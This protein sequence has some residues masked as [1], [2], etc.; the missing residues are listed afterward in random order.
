MH[1]AGLVR[2]LVRKA[3][4]IVAADGAPRAVAV[5]VRA[6]ALSHLSAQHLRAHFAAASQGTRLDG[7]ELVVVADEDPAA[8][9]A[10]N[11]VLVSVEVTATD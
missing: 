3:D 11:L 6:G 9:D 8:V 10:Q 1:E 7:A 4:A 2:D 5:S